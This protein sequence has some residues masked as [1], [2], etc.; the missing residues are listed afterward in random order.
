MTE[1]LRG[2]VALITGAGSGIGKAG[3]LLF[4]QAGAKVAVADINEGVGQ[5]AVKEIRD[6]GGEAIFV[7]ADVSQVSQVEKMVQSTAESFG[8]LDI[9]WHN[10]G[11]V[12]P[13][14]VEKTS[15]QDYDLTMAIHIKGGFFGAKFAVEEMKKVGGGAML[16]TSSLAGLRAS[17]ASTVYSIAKA[18][19]VMLTKNLTVHYARYNVRVNCICP[20]GVPTPLWPVFLSRDSDG[21]DQ[22]KVDEVTKMY[23]Q[24]TP[25]GRLAKPEEIGRAALFLCSDAASYVT[26]E[27]MSVDGGLS[28][29]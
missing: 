6:A 26:G 16:F 4:A 7:R 14:A 8:R 5:A 17:R 21:I 29:T 18:G 20:G 27:I 25:L 3:A 10:A 15:E 22:Q 19:L 2:K 24:K 9:F 11:N 13:G 23:E 1:N 12:G 28:V